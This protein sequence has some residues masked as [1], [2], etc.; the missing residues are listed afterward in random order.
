MIIVI[1]LNFPKLYHV[2][3]KQ[4]INIKF[5]NNSLHEVKEVIFNSIKYNSDISYNHLIE[6][7]KKRNLIQSLGEIKLEAIF[8]KLS[9]SDKKINIDESKKILEELIYMVNNN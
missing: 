7:L 4:L 8:S 5:S 9:S 6:N 2:F 1:I 3:E